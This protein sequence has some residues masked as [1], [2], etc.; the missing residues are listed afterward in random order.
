MRVRRIILL[1]AVSI[2][3]PANSA[4]AVEQSATVSPGDLNG[5]AR[6]AGPCPTFN[7]TESPGA[8]GYELVIY[9]LASFEAKATEIQREEI[10]GQ[11]TGWTPD[12]G[13]C[14]T[15]GARYGWSVRA[16][17]GAHA[18]AWSEPRL[19]EIASTPSAEDLR[20]SIETLRAY[21]EA[22]IETDSTLAPSY[23]ECSPLTASAGS[24]SSILPEETETSLA[25]AV[26]DPALQVNGAPVVTT[27]TLQDGVCSLVGLRFVDLG[28][29]TILDC[30]T[31]LL[32]LKD[33]RC[34]DLPGSAD[35]FGAQAAAAAL[36]DG[37]CGLTDGSA[38]GDWRLPTVSEFCS[39]DDYA[40]CGSD[41][42]LCVRCPEL[43]RLD[44]LIDTRWSTPALS[45]ADGEHEW[46][47]AN[48]F[49]RVYIGSGGLGFWTSS[50]VG[51]PNAY[52]VDEGFGDIYI[53]A[54]TALY[55]IWPVRSAQ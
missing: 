34:D 22:E 40:S 20:E 24:A 41:V 50:G 27:A 2:I 38:A 35:F 1:G 33:A 43:D 23:V 8:T 48:P 17:D 15:Q 30:N 39:Y 49:L 31:Q 28:D 52:M 54:K 7:W 37:L 10:P 44:S 26:G 53:E 11:A 13:S 47:N 45:S 21:L 29:G 16:V 51:N 42:G 12:L 3:W 25:A 14:L 19:F 6:I 9:E 55:A 4:V 5:T 18:S 32:W 46:C 36:Q